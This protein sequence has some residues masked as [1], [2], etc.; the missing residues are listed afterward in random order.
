MIPK[1]RRLH[2]RWILNV[3]LCL[4]LG[5]IVPAV[6]GLLFNEF[7]YAADK[8]DV[9]GKRDEPYIPWPIF[10]TT[11]VGLFLVGIGMI[12][13]KSLLAERYDPNDEDVEARKLYGQSRATPLSEQEAKRMEASLR[14]DLP[15][16]SCDCGG[17]M[18]EA[19][20][21][22]ELDG[23][24]SDG[25]EKDFQAGL[26]K[27]LQCHSCGTRLRMEPSISAV[28]CDPD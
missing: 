16:V 25:Q 2:R 13:L 9:F 8:V 11:L 6:I 12:S 26:R 23:E 18:V 4:T 3:G 10:V 21:C 22:P 27:I 5:L 15:P 24:L 19:E 7:R 14:R 17:T 28:N 1:A 20:Y